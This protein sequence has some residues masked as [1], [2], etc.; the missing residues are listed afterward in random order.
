MKL[1]IIE[2]KW[3][4]Y[5]NAIVNKCESTILPHS[6]S[7][8]ETTLFCKSY[9][10]SFPL[11][12]LFLWNMMFDVNLFVS[13][14]LVC[15]FV[16]FFRLDLSYGTCFVYCQNIKMAI[17]DPIIQARNTSRETSTGNK[18]LENT[19]YSADRSLSRSYPWIQS[20]DQKR[21]MTVSFT[22]DI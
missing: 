18:A 20:P 6:V 16:A 5:K 22:K 12:T 13:L 1:L 3:K 21:P 19:I 9:F 14:K 10:S 8:G 11:I 15:T 17:M 2:K 7:P 4:L